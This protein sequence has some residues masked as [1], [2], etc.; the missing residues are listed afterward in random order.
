VSK[1]VQSFAS[2][3]FQMTNDAEMDMTNIENALNS[4]KSSFSEST[5]PS[6]EQGQL[7]YDTNKALLRHRGATSN[8]KGVIAFEDDANY[9]NITKIWVYA[10]NAEEGFSEDTD[11]EDSVL[12]LKGGSQAYSTVGGDGTPK[13]A[14]AISGINTEFS[15]TH[16]GPNHLHSVGAGLN[17]GTY[18]AVG[19]GQ[20]G[21]GQGSSSGSLTHGHTTLYAG[22]GATGGGSAHTH[23]QNGNWRPQAAVGIMIYPKII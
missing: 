17:T 6:A 10:N 16:T 18:G 13:G 8:W 19:P 7:W 23:S 11:C 1:V 21:A 5:A 14:W 3:L 15:H 9:L 20:V 2:D 22:T 4:L 12:G